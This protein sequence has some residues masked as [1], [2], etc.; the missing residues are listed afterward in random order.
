MRYNQPW[1]GGISRR[2]D[3][4]ES[5][6]EFA[7]PDQHGTDPDLIIDAA[8]LED[9]PNVYY[10]GPFAR[11]VS[12]ASQQ[13][14]AL[15]LVWALHKKEKFRS[16]DRVAV[17]GAGIAGV[18]AACALRAHEATVDIFDRTLVPMSRQMNAHHRMVHPNV[19]F[20]PEAGGL[21]PTTAQ[22]FLEWYY[23]RCSEVIAMLQEQWK[24]F[25]QASGDLLT[26]YPQHEVLIV[27][28]EGSRAFVGVHPAMRSRRYYRIAIVTTG[29]GAEVSSPPFEAIDYW[30]SDDLEHHKT[31]GVIRQFIVSGCGDGGMIDALRLAYHLD[32]GGLAVEVAAALAETDIER[33]LGEYDSTQR[34]VTDE[35]ESLARKIDDDP[36]YEKARQVLSSKLDSRVGL[37]GLVDFQHDYAFNSNAAP[38]HKLL[39]AYAKHHGVIAY[40]KGLVVQAEDGSIS[41][42]F[43]PRP[44]AETKV[45]VR[46][47]AKL[48]FGQLLSSDEVKRLKAKQQLLSSYNFKPAYGEYPALASWPKY[49][50]TSAAFRSHRRGLAEK[51]V[52]K[53]GDVSRVKVTSEGFEVLYTGELS[54]RPSQLFKVSAKFKSEDEAPRGE[55]LV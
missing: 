10:L 6:S 37:V 44:N 29:F 47:G 3:G 51:A 17:V 26:F 5:R 24:E 34:K 32:L 50:P 22:P 41:T 21:L 48:G 46:H 18:T 15:N 4:S 2:L 42:P 20:W 25:D 40:K 38:I 33:A 35:Y 45:V 30:K 1:P 23:G 27:W 53:F 9:K 16:N 55:F 12:F 8:Y 7:M 19:N 28:G 54:Y 36:T 43:G 13:N 31:G 49:D 52:R 11:R 14:R 39:V